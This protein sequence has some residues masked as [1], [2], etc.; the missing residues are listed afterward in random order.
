MLD[1][2]VQP[3]AGIA[4]PQAHVQLMVCR[5]PMPQPA[6]SLRLQPYCFASPPSA[7]L[8]TPGP[9]F[10]RLTALAAAARRRHHGPLHTPHRPPLRRRRSRSVPERR[11]PTGTWCTAG[12]RPRGCRLRSCRLRS[13]RLKSC[14]LRSCRLRSC[15]ARCRSA[16]CR[17]S[18]A[19][20]TN[21][22]PNPNPDPNPFPHTHRTTGAMR[23]S[24]RRTR[25]SCRSCSTQTW[26]LP[27]QTRRRD[28]EIVCAE[29]SRSPSTVYERTR[30]IGSP[31]SRAREARGPCCFILIHLST[32]R[33]DAQA[34]LEMQQLAQGGDEAGDPSPR[35]PVSTGSSLDGPLPM[36]DGGKFEACS[37]THCTGRTRRT[38]CAPAAATARP[39]SHCTGVLPQPGAS[40]SAQPVAPSARAFI[41]YPRAQ[42]SILPCLTL[43]AGDKIG[44]WPPYRRAKVASREQ[45]TAKP[46]VEALSLR[47]V[48][49]P[50]R[51]S[52]W[53][54]GHAPAPTRL[55]KP[56]CSFD[57][58]GRANGL[59]AR[60]RTP[61]FPSRLLGRAC[62]ASSSA[63][64][65]RG[66]A[67]CRPSCA[68]GSALRHNAQP[69]PGAYGCGLVVVRKMIFVW[70]S[71]GFAVCTL[72]T[73]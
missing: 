44:V 35:Q 29:R 18:I 66:R 50:R 56:T 45:Q 25:S 20:M 57:A 43:P 37:Y 60:C 12:R 61:C 46:H 42:S 33:Y 68:K 13:C 64:I 9:I 47:H 34:Q 58:F 4:D 30:T 59:G 63:A 2:F 51:V 14:R 11:F 40:A 39:R 67:S 5:P 27:W 8:C 41:V 62:S 15:K 1:M 28:K 69:Q 3:V 32:Y 24:C 53:C 19:H 26:P 17:G 72:V 31:A 52:I 55:V 54:L 48:A 36:P 7:P 23:A 21:Q 73:A 65:C 71:P 70:A 49:V 22:N 10:A 38:C 16:A 6:P